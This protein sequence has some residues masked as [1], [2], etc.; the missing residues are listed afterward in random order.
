MGSYF[1]GRPYWAIVTRALRMRNQARL[2]RW[3]WGGFF[4]KGIKNKIRKREPD[5]KNSE[6]GYLPPVNRGEAWGRG[7][8][9]HPAGGRSQKISRPLPRASSR[10]QRGLLR[11][12]SRPASWREASRPASGREVPLL[13]IF[14]IFS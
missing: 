6:N 12:A 8:P 14:V 2:E 4:K 7:P 9:A 13:M 10:T 1:T 3:T 11:Q 5:R